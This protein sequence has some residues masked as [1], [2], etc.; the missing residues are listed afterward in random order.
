MQFCVTSKSGKRND[1]R[2]ADEI[3][4]KQ[5][6]CVLTCLQGISLNTACV[7]QRHITDV[8]RGDCHIRLSIRRELYQNGV[9]NAADMM[10]K[11][12]SSVYVR[13]IEG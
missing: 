2:K 12:T 4:I 8:S 6:D 1:V 3:T 11:D 10:V 5:Q 9:V 13:L 7:V